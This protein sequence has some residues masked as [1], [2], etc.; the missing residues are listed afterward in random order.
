M[1]QMQRYYQSAR[2]VTAGK[3]DKYLYFLS[4]FTTQKLIM[5]LTIRFVS[6]NVTEQIIINIHKLNIFTE[7]RTQDNF[8]VC[9]LRFCNLL[10]K[11]NNVALCA[12]LLSY[13]VSELQKPHSPELEPRTVFSSLFL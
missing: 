13:L 4:I 3:F 11:T 5:G 9:D 10:A 12:I 7:I 2:I 6:L 1:L 8:R